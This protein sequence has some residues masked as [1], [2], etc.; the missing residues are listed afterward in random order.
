MTYDEAC[1]VLPEAERKAI[2]AAVKEFRA[3]A[4]KVFGIETWRQKPTIR[5]IIQDNGA[6]MLQPRL[7]WND[8]PKPN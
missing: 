7:N 2:E 8:P 3:A 4:L 5:I 6:M 1:K